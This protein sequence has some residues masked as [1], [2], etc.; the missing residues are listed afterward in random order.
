MENQLKINPGAVIDA[1]GNSAEAKKVSYRNFKPVIDFSKCIKCAKCWMYCPAVAYRRNK[2]GFF[3]CIE[4]YCDG[5]GLCAHI[6]PPKCIKME[7][8]GK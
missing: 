7:V 2:E 5:C 8:V 1:P 6:C 3:E 4:R